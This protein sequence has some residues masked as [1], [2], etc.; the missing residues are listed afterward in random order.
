MIAAAA[1]HPFAYVWQTLPREFAAGTLPVDGM[2]LNPLL[3]NPWMVIHPPVLFAG[4]AAAAIPFA[5]SIAAGVRS[6]RARYFAAISRYNILALTLLGVGIFLGGYWAYSVLGWGGFWGWDPVENSSL[7]IWLVQI[8]LV[9]ACVLYKKKGALPKTT[10]ILACAAYF[11]VWYAAYLTRSGVLNDF[12]VH[13]FGAAGIEPLLR[14]F[15]IIMFFVV[16]FISFYIA[17][18]FYQNPLSVQPHRILDAG[19]RVTVVLFYAMCT[20]GM[21]ALLI[22]IATSVPVF[23]GIIIGEPAAVKT[24]FYTIISGVFGSVLCVLIAFSAL[25]GTIMEK[26]FVLL[27]AGACS[28]LASWLFNMGQLHPGRLVL[29]ASAFFLIFIELS[30]FYEKK[31]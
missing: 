3:Q 18:A 27:G 7:V 17:K 13:A 1:A 31:M 20:C 16:L 9:H 22:F 28:L 5:Y 4:Y 12:S 21:Y 24:S 30:I 15:I 14:F 11:L 19:G 26:R 29:A 2:G 8:A 10:V 25:T 6:D 23:S